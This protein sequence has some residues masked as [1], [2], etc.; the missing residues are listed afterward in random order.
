MITDIIRNAYT[1]H[2][3]SILYK[4]YLVWASI[5]NTI[6]YNNNI[7]YIIF[8]EQYSTQQ[9]IQTLIKKKAVHKNLIMIILPRGMNVHSVI[10]DAVMACIRKIWERVPVMRARAET[11]RRS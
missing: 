6:S 2:H 7:I 9:C 5:Y 4:N 11:V 8:V 1:L 10:D 3:S